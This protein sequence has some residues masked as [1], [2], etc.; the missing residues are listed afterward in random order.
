MNPILMMSRENYCKTPSTRRAV[1]RLRKSGRVLA[2]KTRAIQSPPFKPRCENSLV[3]GALADAPP[4]AVELTI[5]TPN[6]N[7]AGL[8][9]RG[10]QDEIALQIE[11]PVDLEM[12][13]IQTHR[14]D[15][16]EVPVSDTDG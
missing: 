6:P 4:L 2:W 13:M 16:R 5:R 3:L 8:H 15:A 14:I 11:Q 10:L 1:L 7:R 12:V 9:A